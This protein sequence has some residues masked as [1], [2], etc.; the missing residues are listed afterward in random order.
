MTYRVVRS[1]RR[2]F[3]GSRLTVAA[4]LACAAAVCSLPAGA[5]AAPARSG[6]LWGLSLTVAQ[7]PAPIAPGV[8]TSAPSPQSVAGELAQTT[9]LTPAQVQAV[10]VCPPATAQAAE[11]DAEV[12]HVRATGALVRPRMTTA[13]TL[14]RVVL[15]RRTSS[16]FAAPG[17]GPAS[18]PAQGPPSPMTP[19]FLQQ[20]YDLT[21]LSQTAGVG[22][23]VGIV[24]AYD[25]PDVEAD[26]A[27]YRDEFG[28]PTCTTANGCFQKVNQRGHTSPMPAENTEWEVEISLDVD[29][30]SALCPNCH[31]VLV[32]TNSSAWNDLFA[33]EKT[34]VAM[35]ANQ[36]SNSYGGP[37]GPSWA[38]D[39]SFPGVSVVA[40]T[41]DNGF[42]ATDFYPAAFAGVSA[43]GATTLASANGAQGGRGYSE[44]AW[45]LYDGYGGGSGCDVSET[46]PSY[47]T[48]TGCTGRS[49]SDISADGSPSTGLLIYDSGNGGTLQVGGTSLASPLVAAYYALT[50]ADTSSP[51][52][53]YANSAQLN[54]P[55]GGSN[56]TCSI[57][58][59]C[60]AGVGY[61]GPTGAGSISGA[62][63][64][65]APGI[66]GPSVGVGVASY[67]QSV[68]TTTATLI[69]GVYPNGADTT[70]LWEYGTTNAYGQTSAA[71]EVGAGQAPVSLTSTLSNLGPLSTYHYRLVASNSFGTTYGYDYTLQ[72]ADPLVPS[73]SVAPAVTGAAYQGQTLSASLG[74]WTGS[75]SSY[76]YQWQSNTGSGFQNLPGASNATYTLAVGDLGANIRVAVTAT[77]IYGQ[78]TVTSAPVGP[79]C[80]GAPANTTLPT[81][82]G[83]LVQGQTLNGAQGTW[84]PSG[85]SYSYQWQ[86]DSGSGFAN[87][88]GAS[89]Q[90]YQLVL[91]DVGTNIQVIVTATN[92]YGQASATSAAVGP[93]PSGAPVNIAAPSVTGTITL[94]DGSVLTAD[95]GTWDTPSATFTY[96][97]ERC[98]T[99]ASTVNSSCTAVSGATATSTYTLSTND[100]G[101][102]VAV[103]VTASSLGGQTTAPSAVSA[104]ITAQPMSNTSLPGITGNAQVSQAV[105]ATAGSWSAPV[106]YVTY[107]WYRCA[108]GTSNCT[109]LVANS[110]SYTLT[111]AEHG[112]TVM[113]QALATSTG[114]L[115]ATAASTPVTVSDQALPQSSSPPTVPVNTHIP[116][117][118]GTAAM[119]VQIGMRDY[120]WQATADTN[121]SFSWQ[122]CGAAGA[123]CA[124]I[125]GATSS[126]Y[127]PG[128]AD[129]G[130]TLVG[131]SAASDPDATVSAASHPSGVVADAP[132][133][134]NLLPKAPADPGHVGDHLTLTAGNWSGSAIT[135][136]TAQWMRC[137]DVCAPVDSSANPVY[138]IASTDVG[139]VL[140]VM[141]TA[142]NPSGSTVVWSS[143]Y[144]GPV[145]SAS[146]GSSVLGSAPNATAVKNSN[147]VTLALA[148]LST[149]P[150]QVHS[151]IASFAT[152]ARKANAKAPN[153]PVMTVQLRRARAVVGELR[154]WACPLSGTLGG[155]PPK[156]S[157]PVSLSSSATLTLPAGSIGKV[158]VVVRRVSA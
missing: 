66:G 93:V 117:L 24:D 42:N 107:D 90:S 97:W 144:V 79:V 157:R 124:T 81:I 111:A 27:V 22:D 122:R 114:G 86:R 115:T 74:T 58:Y 136:D 9:G 118:F 37:L 35:G 85:T 126:L 63:R 44:S 1:A 89:G 109:L 138:V 128:A 155:P 150:A 106:S 99:G 6:G 125:P 94:N 14:T 82:A 92:T 53:A 40:G 108:D 25:D 152:D 64:T 45:S 30:V 145:S 151:E 148:S 75:P 98:P 32:E 76:A 132:P 147:G 100:I 54:D 56:G 20:A 5:S 156:C 142:T 41:G 140:R 68:T 13:R 113:V 36:I 135:S 15:S 51:G 8:P 146:A 153:A 96:T 102:S 28:L 158:R 47:Q 59:I 87:I 4:I 121:Y 62:V 2:G 17:A 149:A 77:N 129:V 116:D 130:H 95:H 123:G 65:G 127:T 11:C 67:V 110:L 119:L 18:A 49:Y 12:L 70:Y 131:I 91:A 52:W 80:S 29:A 10:A 60:N 31:I 38:V 133:R 143:G 120:T 55:S 71:V 39:Y 43:A 83:S 78:G 134:W 72:T 19:A 26:L 137:T 73:D 84:T 104:A 112:D 88:T 101:H 33:G 34:A 21:Y 23:T 50:G 103:N 69:G 48:D 154:A 61:D 7:A 57:L 3:L 46:K 105:S 16:P 141:E 139:S